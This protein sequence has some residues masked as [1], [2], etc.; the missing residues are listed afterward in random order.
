[1]GKRPA[2]RDMAK[3]WQWIW[4]FLV[5]LHLAAHCTS[6]G[7]IEKL[8]GYPHDELLHREGLDLICSIISLKSDNWEMLSV[9]WKLLLT[10]FQGHSDKKVLVA[11]TKNK[12]KMFWDPP[13]FL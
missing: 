7:V 2:R 11:E 8:V 6:S 5:G 3:F 4:L 9:E 12:G 1:M 13:T 10:N